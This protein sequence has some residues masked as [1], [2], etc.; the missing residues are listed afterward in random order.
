M[1]LRPLPIKAPLVQASRMTIFSPGTVSRRFL[2]SGAVTMDSSAPSLNTR[3]Q[4]LKGA[5]GEYSPWV[6]I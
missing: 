6:E 5:W 1:L 3:A 2:S 4:L